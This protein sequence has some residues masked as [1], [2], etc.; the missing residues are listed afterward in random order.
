[1]EIKGKKIKLKQ[2]KLNIRKEGK[3]SANVSMEIFG[4]SKPMHAKNCLYNPL[5]LQA[6]TQLWGFSYCYRCDSRMICMLLWLIRRFGNILKMT[7]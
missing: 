1:M 4:G 6:C 2:H 3:T 7:S 5:N